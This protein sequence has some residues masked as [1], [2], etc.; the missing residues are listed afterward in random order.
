MIL[1]RNV[2]MQ[3]HRLYVVDGSILEYTGD[4]DKHWLIPGSEMDAACTDNDH[5]LA[6]PL[7]P[8]E[9]AKWWKEHNP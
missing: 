7:D 5:V 3:D 9:V 2:K 6:G 4:E 1:A 8:E